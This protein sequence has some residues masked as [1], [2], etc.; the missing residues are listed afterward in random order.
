M[1]VICEVSPASHS[2]ADQAA[3]QLATREGVIPLLSCSPSFHPPTKKADVAAC[4][5]LGEW[6]KAELTNEGRDAARQD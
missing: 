2:A 6:M 4:F 1:D 3:S 5:I